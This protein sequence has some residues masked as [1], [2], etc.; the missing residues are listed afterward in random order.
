M[1][2]CG[3]PQGIAATRIADRSPGKLSL[4]SAWRRRTTCRSTLEAMSP[5]S[6]GDTYEVREQEA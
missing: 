1:L 5:P 4:Q 2:S 3:P 6:G